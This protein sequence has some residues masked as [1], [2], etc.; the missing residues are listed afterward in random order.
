MSKVPL[1]PIDQVLKEARRI[2][3][4]DL[5]KPGEIGTVHVFASYEMDPHPSNCPLCAAL[6]ALDD[7]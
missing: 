5:R 2:P 4:W 7:A 1:D 3:H 6:K